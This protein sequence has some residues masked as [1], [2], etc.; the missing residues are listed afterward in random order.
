MPACS[1]GWASIRYCALACG[2]AKAVARRWL[3]QSSVRRSRHTMAWR[4]S[5]KQACRAHDDTVFA[6]SASPRRGRAKRTADGPDRLRTDRS[7]E[8][9]SELQ[10]LMR[11]SYAVFCLKKKNEDI[12]QLISTKTL[13]II[14]DYPIDTYTSTITHNTHINIHTSHQPILH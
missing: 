10:S 6:S 5:L 2:W 1:N 12:T 4:H 11:I 9:T 14:P 7:E 3:P 13:T 8:H